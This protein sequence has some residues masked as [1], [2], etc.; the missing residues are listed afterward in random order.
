MT[1]TVLRFTYDNIS[2][3][4]QIDKVGTALS[5][6]QIRKLSLRKLIGTDSE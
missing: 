2:F 4:S 3:H 6:L 1:H 5:L